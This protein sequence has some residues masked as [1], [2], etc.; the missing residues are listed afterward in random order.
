[1]PER[2]LNPVTITGR[3]GDKVSISFKC[4]NLGNGYSRRQSGAVVR[5][6]PKP[7]SKKQRIKIRAARKTT[8]GGKEFV[9]APGCGA[10]SY[11]FPTTWTSKKVVSDSAPVY[12]CCLCGQQFN[13]KSVDDFF[14]AKEAANVE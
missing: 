1:M 12:Q 2:V 6:A 3:D 7:P 4:G 14:A 11:F 13:T 10:L 9:C 5:N 8:P